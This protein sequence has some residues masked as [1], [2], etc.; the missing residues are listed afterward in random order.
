[1]VNVSFKIILDGNITSE[2]FLSVLTLTLTPFLEYKFHHKY[3]IL[4]K[5]G[6]ISNC[7]FVLKSISHLFKH[8]TD[9]SS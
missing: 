2:V 4:L 3:N 6:L 8:I 5:I 1:M 9:T 7:V